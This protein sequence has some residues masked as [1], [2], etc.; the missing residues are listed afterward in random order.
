MQFL[1]PI[2]LGALASL[3]LPIMI[4]LW[5]VRKGKTLKIGSI[6][7][8][9]ESS[10]SN[11][12][13]LRISDWLLLF[14]RCL[15]LI[16][17]T[18]LLAKPFL[19]GKAVQKDQA[20]WILLNEHEFKNSYQSQSKTIDSL[21]TKGYQ[22]HHF[23]HGFRQLSLKDTANTTVDTTK[24]SMLLNYS[25]LLK[26]VNNQLPNGYPV[27]VF[28]NKNISQFDEVLPKLH[29]QLHWKT[30]NQKDTLLT[31]Y[32]NF[33]NRTYK[34]QSLANTITYTPANY[35]KLTPIN[36]VIHPFNSED[37]KYVKAALAAIGLYL[38]Q[39]INF[40]GNTSKPDQHTDIVFWLST[41]EIPNEIYR[42]LKKDAVLFKYA[43]GKIGSNSSFL[44]M[45]DRDVHLLP[46]IKV[47]K[48]II[49]NVTNTSIL[50]KDGF[51]DPLLTYQDSVNL[52]TYTFY[53]QLNPKWTDLV[54][55]DTFVE[56]IMPLIYHENTKQ[57]G[58]AQNQ[59]QNIPDHEAIST[60]DDTTEVKAFPASNQNLDKIIWVMAFLILLAERILTFRNQSNLK[61]S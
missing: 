52:H 10:A 2:G 20:G 49:A 40:Y 44:V 57:F 38:N 60:F 42:S 9:G 25:S 61:K 15:L 43:D 41:K 24:S 31:Y 46:P 33:L 55:Q 13:S 39:Q 18:L 16:L 17:V 58:F 14:L 37:A 53:S 32:T 36:V 29:F 8:L 30:L 56:A 50:W 47:F 22:I 48:T 59:A 26:Q 45:H 4:H 7:L 19:K 51:G 54:W 28:A 27:W 5:Q 35:N 3:I 23:G 21:L 11:A 1:Y 34:A 6:S 12:R